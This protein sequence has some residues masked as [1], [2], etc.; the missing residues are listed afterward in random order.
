MPVDKFAGK[1][2]AKSRD[3]IRNEWLVDY[4]FR[5]PE[6]D[7]SQGTQPWIDASAAADM[8]MPVYYDVKLIGS[9]VDIDNSVGEQ[10]DAIGEADGLPRLPESTAQGYVS[11]TASVGGGTVLQGAEIQYLATRA[12]YQALVTKSLTSTD[13][14]FA[15]ASISTGAGVNLPIGAVL[16][17]TNPP[18]G[19]GSTVTVV[20]DGIQGGGPKEDDGTY[21]ARIKSARANPAAAANWAHYAKAVESVITVNVEKA[22]VYPAVAGPG[23]VGVAFTVKPSTLGGARD[24]NGAQISVIEAKVMDDDGMPI[25]DGALFGSIAYH[26]VSV[27]LRIQ[28]A[29][30]APGWVDSAPWPPSAAAVVTVSNAVA[31]TATTF[32][33][34]RVGAVIA[35]T[36]GK[37]I[38][39][40]NKTTMSMV[41]K[42]IVGVVAFGVFSWDLTLDASSPT[43]DAVYVP[44]NG[45]RVS[46]WAD[47]ANEI[48]PLVLAYMAKQ[49]P[50]EQRISL[51]DPNGREQR[52]PISPMSWPSVIT[53]R[54]LDEIFAL[55]TIVSDVEV[56]LP[57]LPFPTTIGA[58][59]T[60]SYLHRL[61]DLS[62]FS[63]A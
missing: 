50:G 57:I 3:T 40:W 47:S 29:G 7:V 49:G 1:F 6:A 34:T 37:T 22:F 25:D 12:K 30:S 63:G 33:V 19:L 54:M 9:V 10:L 58:T 51:N 35:P 2:V 45:Q 53:N 4:K 8:A 15:I 60:L 18:V 44:A 32:R 42:R 14:V 17:F 28:W 11:A 48:S 62:M 38:A 23:T 41:A 24:P 20:G 55:E 52:H 5:L 16:Q 59:G 36:V 27:T 61:S 21:L 46:P 43:S 26:D 39:L 31:I 56:L 13:L